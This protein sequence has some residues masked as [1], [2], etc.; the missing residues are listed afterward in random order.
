[1]C[2]VDGVPSLVYNVRSNK[3]RS[4]RGEVCFPGGRRNE[5]EPIERTALREAYEEM[6]LSPNDVTIIGHTPGTPDR[7]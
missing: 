3:L 7:Y 4:H 6:G 5:N 1:M 2:T